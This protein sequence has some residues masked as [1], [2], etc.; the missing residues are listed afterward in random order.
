VPLAQ[1]AW[2]ENAQP[3]QQAQPQRAYA[4]R[5][6]TH[7]EIIGGLDEALAGVEGY[8]NNDSND[9]GYKNHSSNQADTLST[10]HLTSSNTT[11]QHHAPATVSYYHCDQIGTPRELTDDQGAVTWSATYKAWG[12]V[13][14]EHSAIGLTLAASDGE[15]TSG[16]ANSQAVQPE[17]QQTHQPLRFQG[18]YYDGETGLHYNHFRYYD[19]DTARY[20]NLDPIGLTG[21]E[22]LYAYAPNPLRW[23]DPL[24]LAKKCPPKS[25]ISK[26]ITVPTPSFEA[27]RNLA[28]AKIGPINPA[29]YIRLIGSMPASIG[30]GR[31]I[32]FDAQ[33][34]SGQFVRYRLD[35][36]PV[37]GTHINTQ[38]GKGDCAEKFAFTFPGTEKEFAQLLK[39]MQ[40]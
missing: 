22:N 12:R 36:D 13:E 6:G 3:T 26:E 40:K 9:A 17:P 29:T 16:Y 30:N 11:T 15:L 38:K 14:T 8:G 24:G 28:L 5:T 35:Y 32:G 2:A 23:V 7:D 4:Q 37:K 34:P 27:A 10:V 18:Q 31:V 39:H 20:I 19:P 25:A 33:T 1:L 21:G